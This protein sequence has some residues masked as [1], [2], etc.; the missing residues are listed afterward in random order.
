MG[1]FIEYF[2]RSQKEIQSLREE[3]RLLRDGI[4]RLTPQFTPM[5]GIIE[6][7]E[8]NKVRDAREKVTK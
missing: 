3:I 5:E 4:N 7:Q 1:E 6:L 2:D 8:A